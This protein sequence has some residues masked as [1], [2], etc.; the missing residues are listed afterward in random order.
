MSPPGAPLEGRVALV[1]GATRG[2]GRAIA[3]DLA[4]LGADVAVIGRSTAARS[5]YP[6]SVPETVAAIEALGRRACPVVADVLSDTDLQRMVDTTLTELG[7]LDLLVNNA[8]HIESTPIDT[9]GVAALERSWAANVRAPMLLT[10]LAL[11]A[12]LD[13]RGAIVNISSGAASHPRPP[14]EAAPDAPRFHAGPEYGMTKA[15]L[16]RFTTGIAEQLADRG[17]AAISIWPGFTLTERNQARTFPG[18]DKAT[19][20]PMWVTSRTVAHVCCDP[21]RYTGRVLVAEDH[22]A[23]HHLA[24]SSDTD[25]TPLPPDP[26]GSAP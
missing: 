11:P 17:V 19:A 2:I 23:E 4:R 12:L 3:L 7:R 6:G 9:D 26:A 21:I 1:T 25:P 20:L 15:A 16:D 14:S 10:K 13:T 18:I 24:R 5:G 22:V 8:A